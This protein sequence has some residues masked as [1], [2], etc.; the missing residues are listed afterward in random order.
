MATRIDPEIILPP[1]SLRDPK[2]IGGE[3]QL[4]PI[5]SASPPPPSLA[6]PR[7]DT[8]TSKVKSNALLQRQ[9]VNAKTICQPDET[10]YDSKSTD[11]YV[12]RLDYGTWIDC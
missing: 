1:G 3:K 10:K 6:M 4:R 12:N 5:R 9:M 7:R 11:D 8:T 2:A